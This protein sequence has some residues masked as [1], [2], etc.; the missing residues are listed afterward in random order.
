MAIL[1]SLSKSKEAVQNLPQAA[2]KEVDNYDLLHAPPM[3]NSYIRYL[4]LNVPT[5]YCIRKVKTSGGGQVFIQW[6]LSPP[7][8]TWL[9]IL[10]FH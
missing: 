3:P 2:F 9:N 10:V 4:F 8:A 7:N 6:Y 1:S 5:T